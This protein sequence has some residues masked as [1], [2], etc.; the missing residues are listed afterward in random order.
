MP[1]T[2]RKSLSWRG[3]RSEATRS[4]NSGVRRWRVCARKGSRQ[5][6]L[7][8]TAAALPL[9]ASAAAER[10][11]SLGGDVTRNSRAE[12]W[13]QLVAKVGTSTWSAAAQKLP[14]VGYLGS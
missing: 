6:T 14:D 4:N 9:F 13:Q 10:V 12:L 5:E 2:V 7:G 11:I 3:Q 8:N 1:K